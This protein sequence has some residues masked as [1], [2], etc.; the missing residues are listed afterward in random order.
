[1]THRIKYIVEYNGCK[2]ELPTNT[3]EASVDYARALSQKE[4]LLILS[5]IM[6]GDSG[7]ISAIIPQKRFSLGE[8]I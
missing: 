3:F 5:M 2:K 4:E 7:F 8:T 6:L 1:M